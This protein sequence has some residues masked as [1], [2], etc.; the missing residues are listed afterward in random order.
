M[1]REQSPYSKVRLA[2]QFLRDQPIGGLLNAI[3][4]EPVSACHTLDQL[5]M[6]GRPQSRIELPLRN[7]EDHR[8]CC[9]LGN[10]SKT[11]QLLQCILRQGRQAGDLPDHKISDVVDVPLGVNAVDIPGPACAIMIECE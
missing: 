9:A 1:R 4:D 3:V 11:S 6:A 10:V 2:A 7:P 5:L 8:K